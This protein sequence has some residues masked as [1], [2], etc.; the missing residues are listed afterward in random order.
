MDFN[1]LISRHDLMGE[2]AR[3]RHSYYPAGHIE[4]MVGNNVAVRFRCKN[5]GKI[6]TSFLS[7]EEFRIHQNILEKYN[8]KGR[9]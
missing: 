7:Q 4:A 6:S 3:D 1:H 8:S 2:C 5:C 9:L